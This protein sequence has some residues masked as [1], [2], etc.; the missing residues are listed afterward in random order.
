MVDLMVMKN[1][2]NHVVETESPQF[3]AHFHGHETD[4]HGK[5]HDRFMAIFMVTMISFQTT[6]GKLVVF[7]NQ[8]IWCLGLDT[9]SDHF[10]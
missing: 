8:L 3:M 5:H 4:N 1:R 2:K 9:H 10:R 7:S 6:M